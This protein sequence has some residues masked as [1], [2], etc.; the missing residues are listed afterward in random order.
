MFVVPSVLSYCSNALLILLPTSSSDVTA[1]IP[2]RGACLTEIPSPGADVAAVEREAGRQEEFGDTAEG[3]QS[4]GTCRR[5]LQAVEEPDLIRPQK[6][7]G[8]GAGV[9]AAVRDLQRRGGWSMVRREETALVLDHSRR[10]CRRR[11]D[12]QWTQVTWTPLLGLFLFTWLASR[13]RGTTSSNMV[14]LEML[15]RSTARPLMDVL[16]QVRTNNWFVFSE[17]SPFHQELFF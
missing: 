8:Q 6:G 9:E 17:G 10:Q 7:M 12:L 4:W 11:T 3:V 5:N 16:L 15:W 13:M 14:S 1:D 2:S